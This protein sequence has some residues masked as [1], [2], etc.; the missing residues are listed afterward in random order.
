MIR[1]SESEMIKYYVHYPDDTDFAAHARLLQSKWRESKGYDKLKYGNF[2]DIE[3]AKVSKANFLTENIKR[4]VTDSLLNANKFG[5]PMIGEP[6]IWNNLLSSQPLCFNLFGELHYDLE[7]ATNYFQELFPNKIDEIISIKFEYSAGRGDSE[8][9]GDYSAF[10][11]FVEYIREDQLGFIGIEVK[12]S[13]SLK[14]ETKEKAEASFKKNQK[15]YTR[16]TTNEIFIPNSIEKLK[17]IPISQIWRDHILSLAHKKDYN[18]GF[19]IFLYPKSNIECQD[20]VA[21]YKECL[22]S[23]NEEVTGFFP[24]YLEDFIITLRKLVPTD[25]T[26]ELQERYIGIN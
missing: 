19:F 6:R 1:P 25:W 18:E 11:V 13:E 23:D 22:V 12:Y 24:R 17:Q 16:L 20:G 3:F 2:L 14:E 15:A 8:Y 9:T 26:K 10:D 4:L 5:G 7:L 21:K